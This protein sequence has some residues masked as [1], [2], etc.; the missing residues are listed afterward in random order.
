MVSMAGI[1][2]T[3]AAGKASIDSGFYD[4][5]LHRVISAERRTRMDDRYMRNHFGLY[6]RHSIARHMGKSE[7][8]G[9]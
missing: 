5:P 4:T 7:S 8:Y 6:R 2:A 3:C 9:G 1:R